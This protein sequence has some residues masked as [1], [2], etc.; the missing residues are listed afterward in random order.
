MVFP[1]RKMHLNLF[2]YP[3]GHHEAGWR[4]RDTPPESIND[5]RFYQQLTQRAE[6]ARFDA[7]FLADSPSLPHDVRY[8]SRPR[9]EPLTWLSAISSVT[10]HIGLIGTASTTYYEP[11]NL[12]RLF[13]SLD[14][15]S[16]GR[17]GW[18]IVTTSAAAAAA[19][20]GLDA[21][22]AHEERYKRAEEFIEV[23]S[24]LWDSWEEDAIV[25]DK[26]EGIFAN[27]DK[28]RPIDH[29]GHYFDVKGPLSTS[30]TP[31]GRPVY[32]QAGSSP[33]GRAFAARHAEA[34]F[35]AHQTLESAQAFYKDIKHRAGESGRPSGLPLVLPGVSPFIADTE[36]AA[37]QLEEE[38]NEL[39]QPEYS[40]GILK[41]QLGVEFSLE[42][43]DRPVDIAAINEA[44]PLAKASRFQ[45]IADI[46]RREQPTLRQL[47]HRLAGARGHIVVTGT[48]EQVADH[49]EQWFR[50]GAADGFNVMPPWFPGGFD[51]FAEEVV[52][53]LQQRG[54]FR[55]DYEGSTLREHYGLETP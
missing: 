10:S 23:V 24:R 38:F 52:P 6:Q 39:I 19:N 18:N 7:I 49:L 11:F 14:H 37:Q 36:V 5:V 53:L 47:T 46:V 1:H 22:P 29:H 26:A 33:E 48:P 15:L 55:T 2:F 21:H 44:S 13:A 54:L 3:G 42:D 28:I 30:R 31:Q 12:A 16:A 8:T 17:A 43:L 35:T 45:L 4:Y 20:F 40:L 9:I 27:T 51:R 41:A 34:I 50:Q 32:V 25:A